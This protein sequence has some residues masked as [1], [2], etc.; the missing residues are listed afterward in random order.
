MDTRRVILLL[1][2]YLST[3][4]VGWDIGRILGK[5]RV[6]LPSA[7]DGILALEGRLS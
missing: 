1:G 2:S 3:Q 4:Q 7:R 6:D 5:E